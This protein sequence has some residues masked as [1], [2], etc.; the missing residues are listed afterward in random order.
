[1]TNL[2]RRHHATTGA[3]TLAAPNRRANSHAAAIDITAITAA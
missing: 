1:V 2:Q 3:K